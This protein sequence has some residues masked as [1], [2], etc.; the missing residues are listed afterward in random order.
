MEYKQGKETTGIFWHRTEITAKYKGLRLVWQKLKSLGAWF[1]D[2][3]W[4]H[5]RGW[6]S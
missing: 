5:D 1:H 6:I 2:Q 4:F 3:G